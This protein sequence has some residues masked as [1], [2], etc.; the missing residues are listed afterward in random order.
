VVAGEAHLR[1]LR[2]VPGL[3]LESGISSA[4]L[5]DAYRRADVFLHP[6]SDATGNSALMEALACGVP[7]VT[8]DAGGVPD[9]VDG[10]CAVLRPADPARLADAV[11]GLLGDE[12]ERG[13][14]AEAARE[15]ALRFDWP[16]VAWSLLQIYA[17]A[18]ERRGRAGS[19]A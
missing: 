17:D 3:R 14:M 18:L 7:V 19:G 6:V 11:V 13:A 12:R 1:A 8:T 4:E 10:S 15:R 16:H 2:G 9:Y 5:L